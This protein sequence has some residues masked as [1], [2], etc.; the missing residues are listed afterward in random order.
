MFDA[1]K[2]QKKL[3]YLADYGKDVDSWMTDFVKTMELYDIM[4]PRRFLFGSRKL[5]K[6]IFKE[7]YNHW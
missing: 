6:K 7:L 1:T 4:E 3:P 2:L 5:W